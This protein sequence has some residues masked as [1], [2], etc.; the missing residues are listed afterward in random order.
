[1]GLHMAAYTALYL[2]KLVYAGQEPLCNSIRTAESD[3]STRRGSPSGRV[4]AH[5]GEEPDS[6]ILGSKVDRN[7]GRLHKLRSA[8]RQ[9][10]LG[11]P[12]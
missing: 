10:D 3:N 7:T 4:I 2:A 5:T 11:R 8:L 6:G 1:M 12:M 9:T